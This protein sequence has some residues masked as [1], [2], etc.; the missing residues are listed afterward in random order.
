M[1]QHFEALCMCYTAPQPY[2]LDWL[3]LCV[4]C[5]ISHFVTETESEQYLDEV[6]KADFL[7]KSK[8]SG[9]IPIYYP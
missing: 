1:G 5:F 6:E 3:I 9:D 4:F 8:I 7:I 2:Q